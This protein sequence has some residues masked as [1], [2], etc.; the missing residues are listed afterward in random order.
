[1]RQKK[2][3]RGRPLDYE[4]GCSIISKL[5]KGVE[6]KDIASQEGVA[7]ST[8]SKIKSSLPLFFSTRNNDD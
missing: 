3:Q 2:E 1:M 5:F 8:V 4:K 7:H 6:G